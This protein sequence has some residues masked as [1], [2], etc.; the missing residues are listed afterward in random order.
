MS[1]RFDGTRGENEPQVGSGEPSAQ[2]DRTAGLS[3]PAAHGG[4]RRM[5][6]RPQFVTV[7]GGAHSFMP[8]LRAFRYF[9]RA[10]ARTREATS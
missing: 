4:C 7:N 6:A 1:T 2:D 9:L 5:I 8:G 10:G 3:V